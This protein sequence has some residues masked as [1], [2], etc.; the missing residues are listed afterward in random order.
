LAAIITILPST[1]VKIADPIAA[2]LLV[3][4]F[5]LLLSLGISLWSFIP[6]GNQRKLV[7]ARGTSPRTTDNLYF[8]GDVCRYSPAQLATEI[9]RRYDRIADYDPGQ[10]PSHVD[11][12]S[13]IIA[14]SR[15]TVAKN[16]NFRV[17]T[18][19]ALAAFAAAA[20]G[21]VIELVTGR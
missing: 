20:V 13:Q 6:R 14:N 10:H 7:P 21:V 18:V 9:A 17:A 15:I 3:A 2:G 12:A 16:A 19:I 5:L 11:L 8:Y 1:E 4:G